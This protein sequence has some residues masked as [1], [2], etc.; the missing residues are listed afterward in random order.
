MNSTRFEWDRNKAAINIKRH[1]ITF[2]EAS[3]VFLDNLAVIFDDKDHSEQELRELIIGHSDRN[4]ILV[5][6]FTE[7]GEAI[8][9]ISAR[10]ANSKE[11]TAYEQA[12][13]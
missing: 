2:E 13:R 9:L 7:R 6:A 5:V 12:N 1:K 11:Q 8:R 3:T 10:R 4:R